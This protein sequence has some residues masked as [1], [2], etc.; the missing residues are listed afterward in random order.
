MCGDSTCLQHPLSNQTFRVSD[1]SIDFLGKVPKTFKSQFFALNRD[2]G[3]TEV[4]KTPKNVNIAENAWFGA[5]KAIN[6][7]FMLISHFSSL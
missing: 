2:L 5:E 3:V 1:L 7:I 6:E 4:L